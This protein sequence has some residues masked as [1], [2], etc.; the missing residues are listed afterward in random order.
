MSPLAL[1][2]LAAPVW[3]GGEIVLLPFPYPP[4]ALGFTVAT[5]VVGAR[6]VATGVVIGLELDGT[7]GGCE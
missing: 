7:R 5:G 6:V 3:M 4:L 2:P 1:S